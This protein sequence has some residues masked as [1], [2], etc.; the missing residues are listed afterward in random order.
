MDMTKRT[1]CIVMILVV[2]LAIF[3]CAIRSSSEDISERIDFVG[4]VAVY[5]HDELYFVFAGLI[6]DFK[7]VDSG[8]SFWFEGNRYTYINYQIEIIS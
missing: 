6:Q 8:V 2:I 7:Q 4:S 3:S 5:N 1:Y